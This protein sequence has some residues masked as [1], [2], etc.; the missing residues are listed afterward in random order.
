MWSASR[1]FSKVLS[2]VGL[3]FCRPSFLC[4]EKR[5]STCQSH[6]FSLTSCTVTSLYEDKLCW[7]RSFFHLAHKWVMQFFLHFPMWTWWNVVLAFSW[8]HGNCLA[9]PFFCTHAFLCFASLLY[10]AWSWVNVLTHSSSSIELF[11][12]PRA[13]FQISYEILYNPAA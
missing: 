3:E 13:H 1:S 2:S 4:I 12:F 9:Y 11:S 7:I 8:L 6:H 5:I 10:R